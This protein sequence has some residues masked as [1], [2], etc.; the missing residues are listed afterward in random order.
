MLQSYKTTFLFFII[1][2]TSKSN[3][4]LHYYYYGI[5]A[6]ILNYVKEIYFLFVGVPKLGNGFA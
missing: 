5:Y 3:I 1:D 6:I 2:Y 4:L